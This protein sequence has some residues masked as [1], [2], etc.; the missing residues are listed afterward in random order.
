M[1]LQCPKCRE[2]Y[3]VQA[4]KDLTGF[5]MKC[6]NCGQEITT[7]DEI[8]VT[9]IQS[10]NYTVVAPPRKSS[11]GWKWALAIVAAMLAIMLFTKPDRAKHTEKVR[12]L[13][14]GV[15]SEN[16]GAEGDVFTEGLAMLA[17]PFVINQFLEM[18]LQID[19]YIFF[20]VGRIK[21]EE[22]DKP[23]TI[24]VFN[25]VFSLA[26]KKTISERLKENAT[27]E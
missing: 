14:M 11:S 9:R 4:N 25:C 16:L 15:V 24:G 10:D 22:V 13:A 21:Y 17:G 8:K 20:N 12:E 23:I 1:I 26:D 19:D 3:D 6:V 27:A 2:Q 5:T 18:G 7:A